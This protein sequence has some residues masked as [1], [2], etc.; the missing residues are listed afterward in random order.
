MRSSLPGLPPGLSAATEPYRDD[1]L[2]GFIL[3]DSPAF[4]EWQFF[5]TE[6]LRK[7]LSAALARLVQGCRPGISFSRRL[8][9]RGGGRL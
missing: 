9:T 3:R 1:F 8:T 6:G 2:V 4:D 7:E 5:E